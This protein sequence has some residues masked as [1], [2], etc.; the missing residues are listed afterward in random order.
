M[1]GGR[2]EAF[3]EGLGKGA[4]FTVW[5]PL[6]AAG[7]AQPEDGRGTG[8]DIAGVRILLVDDVEEV[9][10]TCRT[11]LELHGAVV[12]GATSGAEALA[13]LADNDVDLLI[14]DI[15]MPG[16]DGYDLLKA[17]RALP[18]Y[19]R[20]PA[21]AVSG[22]ARDKDIAQAR[23]SGFDA[24]LGKPLSV[25]RLTGIIRHLLPARQAAAD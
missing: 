22:L 12:T 19:A 9:V 13:I 5:L 15:S 7:A 25:E 6:A 8:Q 10:T 18:R 23:A 1:H 3:S 20:L 16:M 4:R 11:L 21:I 2:V 24:H 17:A 14:T